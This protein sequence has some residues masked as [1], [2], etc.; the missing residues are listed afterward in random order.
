VHSIPHILAPASGLRLKANRP[1]IRAMAKKRKSTKG[2][3]D[4]AR[5]LLRCEPELLEALREQAE[6]ERR[7]INE[8]A[9]FAIEQY[10]KN[11]THG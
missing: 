9:R 3:A 8:V 7:T 4:R 10:L 5:F 6:R 2:G 1:I 11:Q